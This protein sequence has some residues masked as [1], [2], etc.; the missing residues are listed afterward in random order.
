[1][2]DSGDD[3][4]PAAVPT[5]KEKLRDELWDKI[6]H[7]AAAHIGPDFERTDCSNTDKWLSK[8]RSD[9]ANDAW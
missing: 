4:K 2:S 6:G 9:L 5:E 3:T 8:T 1:M 7:I